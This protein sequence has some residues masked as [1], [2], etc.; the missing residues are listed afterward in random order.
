M[1]EARQL[2]DSMKHR[3]VVSWT[4]IVQGYANSGE[5][6]LALKL[7]S[8]MQDEGHKC[9]RVSILAALKACAS[10]A[11]KED[12]ELL[13]GKHLKVKCLGRVRAL[14]PQVT[15]NEAELDLFVANSLIDVY[16]KCGSMADAQQ[17][18]DKIQHHSVVSWNCLIQGYAESGQGEQALDYYELMQSRGFKADTVTLVA[19]LKACACLAEGEERNG[20]FVNLRRVR[21]IHTLAASN[22]LVDVVLANTLVDS[23]AKCGSMVDARQVFEKMEQHTVVSW[24]VLI[25]GYAQNG[26]CEVALELYARMKDEGCAA[27][28]VTILAALKA[29]TGVAEK[30]FAS[31]TVARTECIW[32]GKSIHAEAARISVE[33]NQSVANTL[34]DMYAKCGSLE[35]ALR[36]F[37]FMRRHD[38]V[39]WNCLI[40]GFAKCGNGDAALEMFSCM[41]DEDHPPDRITFIAALKACASSAEQEEAKVVDGRAVKQE[42][43]QRGRTIHKRAA[44][45]L[46]IL[47]PAMLNTLVDTYAKCG[48]MGDARQ[49]FESMQERSVVSW[50]CIILGYAQAGESEIALQLYAK[51]R[52]DKN[53]CL[54]DAVTFTGAFKACGALGALETGKQIEADVR[55]AGLD[56]DTMVLNSLLDFYCKC[57]S[58]PEAERVFS[59]VSAK[60][61]VTWAALMAGYSSIGQTQRVFQLFEDMQRHRVQPDDVTFLTLL[62]ACSHAGLVDKGKEY[63]QAMSSNKF[64]ISPSRQHYSCMVDMLGRAN[65]LDEAVTMIQSMPGKADVV[66]WMVLLAAAEKWKNVDAGRLAFESLMKLDAKNATAYVLM[67]NIYAGAGMLEEL[68]Q[69]QDMCRQSHH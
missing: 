31:G 7:Y 15:G 23:Y 4:A 46:D 48:S 49:V 5:G 8:R 30:A 17:V 19:A 10:L 26:E 61:Q 47:D 2:F 12:N 13:G 27:N 34:I 58:M 33:M 60:T 51:M 28:L 64:G 21:A 45:S 41:R 16:S 22:C 44:E 39:S 68:V 67:S 50:N 43:L 36:V 56:T 66:I 55:S 25:L 63:F 14:H 69:I 59:S 52:D 18:F 62:S 54:P 32:K 37:Q 42:C 40:H 24:T 65:Q 29:C 11:E 57:G 1:A 6:E 20:M 3:D 9:N 35:D 38:V 53:S